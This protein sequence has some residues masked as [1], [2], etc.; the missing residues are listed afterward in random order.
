MLP[1]LGQ[2]KHTCQHT[3]G[4][5]PNRSGG[6]K[7]SVLLRM[8][9]IRSGHARWRPHGID[10]QPAEAFVKLHAKGIKHMHMQV[11]VIGKIG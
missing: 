4:R 1:I 8:C 3:C 5:G 6:K 9:T 2:P 11:D 10:V 7:Q